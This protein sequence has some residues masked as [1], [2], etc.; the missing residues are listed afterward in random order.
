MLRVAIKS[1]IIYK[2]VFMEDKVKVKILLL[3]FLISI[4]SFSITE[5][6]ETESEKINVNFTNDKTVTQG[7]E[8]KIPLLDLPYNKESENNFFLES[9]SMKQALD[10][11]S[12]LY[13]FSI[14]ET[15][16]FLDKKIKNKNEPSFL[17]GISHA[18]VYLG[19]SQLPL[20]DSWLHEEYHRAVMNKNGID[21][22][23]GV[24]NLKLF[25]DTISVSK[26]KDEDLI[27]LKKNNVNDL[28][29]LHSAGYEGQN[30]LV[31]NLEKETFFKDN[32]WGAGYNIYSLMNIANN[33]LYIKATTFPKSSED[34]DKFNSEENEMKSRD[35]TGYD[36]PAWTYDLFR[37]D[38]PY[39][40]R[41]VHPSGVGID[42][43]IKFSDLTEEEQ[44]YL[45][46]QANL[47]ILSFLDMKFLVS[48]DIQ[49]G[50]TGK[51]NLNL[52]HHLTP[53]GNS[54]NGNIFYKDDKLNLFTTVS[55][56]NNHKNSFYGV[57]FQLVDYP[58]NT[59][60]KKIFLTYRA[61]LWNQPKDLKFKT[62]NGE[63]GG[64]IGINT[65]YYV[66]DKWAFNLNI[67]G[68]TAGWVPSN[69]YLEK[70]ISSSLGISYILD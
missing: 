70:N 26:V 5:N 47:S 32:E 22:Y 51:I 19:I 18:L 10:L 52:K 66:S 16:K 4:L 33:Y 14:T 57:D 56:Y 49:I 17:R 20:G 21:S 55:N 60:N 61:S 39:E 23:N 53:F 62:S 65:K 27:K 42:R 24:Y 45:K 68:K 28:I 48:K 2:I 35:F 44:K 58:L 67:E 7:I 36:F 38:E 11:T 40:N 15:D 69:V 8:L 46:K 41:G 9:P 3:L 43:Y 29:R 30:E 50:E 63:I 37:P 54:I 12:S 59:E 25:S 13:L 34:V 1:K 64:L 31:L 6:K